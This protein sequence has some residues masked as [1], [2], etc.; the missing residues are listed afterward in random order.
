M[1]SIIST[2]ALE[3][4]YGTRRGIEDVNLQIPAGKIFGFLGP[5]GAIMPYG[6]KLRRPQIACCWMQVYEPGN[7]K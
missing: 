6:L 1:N 4:R 7:R 5:N 3:R 2:A